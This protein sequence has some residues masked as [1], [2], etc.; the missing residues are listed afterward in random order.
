MRRTSLLSLLVAL[1]AAS[2]GRGE[3]SRTIVVGPQYEKGAFFRLWFGEGYRDLW[4]TPVELPVLDLGTFAGGLTPERV[5]GGAQSLD[6]AMRGADGRAYTFRSL[7]KHP[8]RMLPPA[9]RDRWPAEIAQDQVSGTHPA[10]ALILVPLARAAGIPTTSPRLV[11]MSD[12]PALGDFRGRFAGQ[13]G[14]IDEYPLP[15]ES[16]SPGFSGA[17]EII[18]TRDLWTRWLK[19]PENRIDSRAFLR[20]RVLDLWVDNF[21]RHAGQWRWM[22]VPGDDHWQPLP[23]DPDMVLVHHDGLV[24]ASLRLHIPRLLKFTGHYSKRLE[25]PLMNDFEVDRWLL[26]DLDREDWRQIAT[27]LQARFT[28]EVIERALRQMPGPWY[29]LEG[30][31]ELAALKERRQHLVDYVLR[32]YAYYAH[33][34]DV[35]ATDRAE[36][37]TIVRGDDD[38]ID[39]SIALAESPGAPY[40]HRRFEPDETDDVRIYLRGGDD[41]VLRTGPPGGPITVRVIGGGGRDVV[42]DSASGGTDVWRDAGRVEVEKGRG[43]RFREKVWRNP[44]PQKDKPWLEPRSFGH[45]TVP[46]AIVGWAADVN[47][48][49]G[50]GLTRTSWGFRETPYATLQT[51]RAAAA[52]GETA[53]KVEY[54]GTFRKA[55]SGFALGL[56]GFA[57]GIEQVNFFGFGND[58]PEVTDRS[59]YRTGENVYFVSP[60][61][62]W[63]SGPRFEVYVGPEVRYSDSP[64]QGPTIV[65]EQAPYGTGRFLAASLRGGLQYDSRTRPTGYATQNLAEGYLEASGERR[66]TGVQVVGSAAYVPKAWD[67]ER[68][69]GSVDGFVAGYVGSPRIHLAVRAGG[70]KVWGIYPWFDAAF[71]GG[72]NDRGYRIRRFA[73]DASLYGSAELRLWAGVVPTPVT[74]MRIGFLGFGDVGQVFVAGED[75]N[76]WHASTGGGLLLE[77]LGTPVTLRATVGVSNE[78]ARFYFGAG[79]AF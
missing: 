53:G 78:G 46:E 63:E 65:G 47:L 24:M 70:R 36:R 21:D 31:H 62:R 30:S 11:V 14:T 33:K 59:R 15:A 35:Q 67:V 7:H 39:V 9:W 72:L 50:A 4:T 38:R 42:D 48:L 49:L 27:D 19:G 20:A 71:I 58:T 60:T 68:G 74:P 45:W 79:Y 16:G 55:A 57:S 75:S 18:S 28:D 52:T 34:V 13:I 2:A 56:H 26:S 22:Q 51:L 23:E 77:P 12:S 8:E 41:R 64:T 1:L 76:T 25:G 73:G 6:L 17:T 69:Y 66:V 37:V 5:V 32:V 54:L 43:T 10:A 40:F 3:E 44:D 29:A 61:L